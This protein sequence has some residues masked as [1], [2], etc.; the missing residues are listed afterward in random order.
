[1][2]CEELLV[3]LTTLPGSTMPLFS[4]TSSLLFLAFGSCAAMSN[5]KGDRHKKA[6]TMEER[7]RLHQRSHTSLDREGQLGQVRATEE[8]AAEYPEGT[9]SGVW[10]AF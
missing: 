7:D 1:M 5:K 2:S 10:S 3:I 9:L 4:L 6:L 8:R